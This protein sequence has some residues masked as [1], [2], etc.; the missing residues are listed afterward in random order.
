MATSDLLSFDTRPMFLQSWAHPSLWRLNSMTKSTTRRSTS[1]RLAC[2]SWK[3][4]VFSPHYIC[5]AL[6]YMLILAQRSSLLWAFSMYLYMYDAPAPTVTHCRVV[7]V[8]KCAC[9]ML[10]VQT[11]K[12][13]AHAH[14]LLL[15]FPSLLFI[16]P[17][18]SLFWLLR[19]MLM[20]NVDR[21]LSEKTGY[22]RVSLLRVHQPGAD[23]P[24]GH[25]GH[26]TKVTGACSGLGDPGIYQPLS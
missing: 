25:N 14:I 6:L 8:S 15:S 9:S 22:E 16:S 5:I 10:L 3:W 21:D 20:L 23:L 19:A 26:Q 1:M 12:T 7:G 2:V 13:N 17:R 18:A 4:Q 24:Q 11:N